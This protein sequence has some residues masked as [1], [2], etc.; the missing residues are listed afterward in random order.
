MYTTLDNLKKRVPEAS[1]IELTDDEN[2]GDV[3]MPFL[4]QAI[5]D[6]DVMIN[7]RLRGRYPVPFS[8]PVPTLIEQLAA[9]ITLHNLYSRKPRLTMPEGLVRQYKTALADLAQLQE[10]SQILEGFETPSS[11]PA[12]I[13]TNKTAEDR[14]FS[15]AFLDQMP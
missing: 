15:K 6:A 5:T 3:H 9:V 12:F 2:T 8:A 1:L 7:S 14:Y 10:G 11:H 4:T 13:A